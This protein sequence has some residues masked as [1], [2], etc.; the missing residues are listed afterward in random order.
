MNKKEFLIFIL[1]MIAMAT[2]VGIIGSDLSSNYIWLKYLC[3][4]LAG[5]MFV[6]VYLRNPG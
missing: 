4:L 2:V 5:I 1:W 6:W 3:N